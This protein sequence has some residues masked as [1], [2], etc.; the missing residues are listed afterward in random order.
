MNNDV[1]GMAQRA[2]RSTAFERVARIG[3][4]ASGVVHLLI[5]WIAAQVALGSSGEADEAGALEQLGSSTGG[6]V[7]LWVCAVAF[8]ALALWHLVEAIVSHGGSGRDQLLDRVKAAGKGVVYGAL[9]FTAFR[10]VTGAGADGGETTSEATATLMAAPA[11]RI[12]VGLLGLVVLG[13]GGYHVVK[14]AKRK[15]LEDL[16]GTGKRQVSRAVTVLGMVGYVAKGAALA[17]MG[18]LFLTAALQADPD[19]PTGLDAALKT[20]RDQPFGV[21]LLLVVAVGL[22]AYGLYSFA[23]ARYSRM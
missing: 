3:Y 23:R 7:L 21:V 17:V 15:F 2:S 16:G 20:L 13:V 5:A 19:Q 4:A 10:V 1:Q 9:A 8:A 14:G 6:S 22:A 18:G 11:G 12:L